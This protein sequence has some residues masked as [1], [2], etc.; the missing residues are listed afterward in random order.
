MSSKMPL[1]I[2]YIREMPHEIIYMCRKMP[3]EIMFMSIEM[4]PIICSEISPEIIH[5][6]S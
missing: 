6:C 5:I 3:H 2:I 4:L 1:E